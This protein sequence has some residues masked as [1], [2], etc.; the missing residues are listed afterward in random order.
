MDFPYSP[1]LAEKYGKLRDSTHVPQ[2]TSLRDV[3]IGV[4]LT[5]SRHAPRLWR[6]MAQISHSGWLKTTISHGHLTPKLNRI[7]K[8]CEYPLAHYVHNSD[9][10]NAAKFCLNRPR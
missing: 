1:P 4:N 5:K 3:A 6:Q 2:T 8:Y 7:S 9:Q 10:T